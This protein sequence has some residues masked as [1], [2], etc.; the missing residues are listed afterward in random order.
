MEE[1]PP[2]L[3]ILIAYLIAAFVIIMLFVN[4]FRF[5]GYTFITAFRQ[6]TNTGAD[7]LESSFHTLT[8]KRF[9]PFLERTGKQLPPDQES[10]L[11]ENFYYYRNLSSH[12][13]RVFQNRVIHFQKNHIVQGWREFEITPE[14]D[15]LVSALAVQLTF[16]FRKYFL[17]AFKR[18]FIV[19]SIYYNKYTKNYHK[20][21]TS[22]MG[23]VVLSWD[24]LQKGIEIPDDNLNLGLHEFA[25][26]LVIQRVKSPEYSDPVFRI[27]YDRL[28]KNLKH[29]EIFKALSSH[30]YFRP[31]AQTNAMEF[32]AVATEAFFETPDEFRR[33]LPR[34]YELMCK[35]YNQDPG[36]GA[37]V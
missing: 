22:P 25:H 9:R 27:W 13:K 5:L 15:L 29:P 28:E 3:L 30:S 19:P 14:M 1:Q 8:R 26:A 7:L 17:S 11:E 35:M 21:E 2:I 23:V 32:F 6:L 12:H 34:L 37:K 36:E 24:Y 20:G 18:I 31:Y 4:L 16:G 33:E 10:W